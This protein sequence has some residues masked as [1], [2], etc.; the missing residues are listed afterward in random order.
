MSAKINNIINDIIND[1]KSNLGDSCYSVIFSY[2]GEREMIRN[3]VIVY[4]AYMRKCFKYR[5]DVYGLKKYIK[6]VKND[7]GYIKVVQWLCEV[8]KRTIDVHT[9]DDS[10]NLR[11][12]NDLA[13][14]RWLHGLSGK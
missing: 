12:R 9:N 3:N 6:C 5:N 7:T 14:A 13:I 4:F 1:I 11:V 2:Y 8:S 10:L